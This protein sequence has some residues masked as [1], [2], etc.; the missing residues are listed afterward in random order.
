MIT[1][2]EFFE[3]LVENGS[4]AILTID[5]DSDIVYANQSAERIFGYTPE[6][7][8][9]EPITVVM[10]DRLKG[11]HHAAVD[12]YLRTGERTL[13]WTNIELP[14]E[15][16]E[17]HEFPVSVT[18]EEHEYGDEKLFSGIVRDITERR[19][20]ERKLERQNEQLEEFASILSHDLRE[21]VNR[22]Q[23]RVSLLQAEYDDDY[24]DELGA[25]HERMADIVEDVLTLAKEGR[26]VGET[27]GVELASL[28]ENAWRAVGDD[29]ATLSVEAGLGT[30]DADPGR[31]QRVLENLLGNAVRHGGEDVTVDVGRLETGGFFIADD[32]PG[33]P[34]TDREEVFAYGYTTDDEGTGFG[35]N[36]VESIVEAHGWT[37]EVTDSK[38][39][40]TRFEVT[41]VTG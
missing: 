26:A 22:A 41:G 39:G 3:T 6:Q 27:T 29:E 5:E 4:D 23:A 7:L 13:D 15:H 28:A 16:A 2:A 17:G 11:P 35:L 33:I 18:F 37:I 8:V 9:G 25:I 19:E 24:L 20:R 34:A 40:G 31:L 30:V 14:A 38:S 21:P 1:D 12:T 32:G 36:I 10:P